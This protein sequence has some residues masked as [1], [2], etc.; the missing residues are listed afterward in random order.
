[1]GIDGSL[2]HDIVRRV[3]A[4][5]KPDKIILFGS[6]ATGTMTRDSDID[7]LVVEADPGDRRRESVRIHNALRGLG[8]PFDVIIISAEWFEESRNVI[9]GI[10]YPANKYGKVVYE[11]A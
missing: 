10:A 4:V 8:Y 9:G 5:A 3:L 2:V 6:A 1:M 7:L 11:A